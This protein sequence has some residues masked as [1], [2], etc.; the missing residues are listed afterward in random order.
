MSDVYQNTKVM[1]ENL[2]GTTH[3]MAAIE[4]NVH[5]TVAATQDMWSTV[6]KKGTGYYIEG[7]MRSIER[8]RVQDGG[9]K[10]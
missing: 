6:D 8:R 3:T 2:G 10:S 7:R 1:H 4:R 5:N 9:N